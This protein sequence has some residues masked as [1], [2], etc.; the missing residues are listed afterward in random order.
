MH[1]CYLGDDYSCFLAGNLCME[2]ESIMARIGRAK[3]MY[4]TGCSY[5]NK[6]SCRLLGE[7]IMARQGYDFD[8]NKAIEFYHKGCELGDWQSCDKVIDV[9]FE[10]ECEDFQAVLHSYAPRSC[11]LVSLRSCDFINANPEL[12]NQK[13]LKDKKALMIDR[14]LFVPDSYNAYLRSLISVS[15]FF[16]TDATSTALNLYLPITFRA[17]FKAIFAKRYKLII[18]NAY[19]PDRPYRK[20]HIT[21]SQRVKLRSSLQ[22]PTL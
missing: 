9:C 14:G 13:C 20:K 3:E 4:K 10:Y 1:A 5:D 22:Y 16:Y 15:C 12:F 7:M 6:D 8:D 21:L 17:I 2:D 18:C 19:S 11:D